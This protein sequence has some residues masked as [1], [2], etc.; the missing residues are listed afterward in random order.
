MLRVGV[1]ELSYT[2]DLQKFRFFV[3]G[4]TFQP[5][6]LKI[7]EGSTSPPSLLNEIDLL[8]AM[9]AHGIGTDM[10]HIQHI[11]AIQN[12][13]K[14]IIGSYKKSKQFFEKILNNSPPHPPR[15][16]MRTIFLKVPPLSDCPH[17]KL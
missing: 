15:I 10:T 12:Q 11:T 6:I 4:N 8:D 16:N 14:F 9:E 17:T 7:V 13:S 2:I 3:I 5:T 1:G